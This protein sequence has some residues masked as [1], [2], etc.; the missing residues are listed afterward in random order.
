MKGYAW[1]AAA[2]AACT[3][4]GLALRAYIDPV[5]IAML[6]LL[7]VVVV[8]LRFSRGAAIASALLCVLAFDFVFVPPYWSF[9]VNDAQYLVT[10]AILLAVGL[11]ISGLVES[12]RAHGKA[13]AAAA[14]EAETER[15]RSALLSSISHDLRTPLAVMSGASSSLTQSGER[16]DAEERRA[17]A[18]SIFEQARAMAEVMSN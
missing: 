5:N 8:A 2:T 18:Q 3:A 17:L 6:Y 14:L 7:A 9:A 16:L 12:G 15:M 4:A 10:F 1:A 11:V 13:R